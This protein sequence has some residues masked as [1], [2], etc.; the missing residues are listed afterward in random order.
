VEN[1]VQMRVE[2]RAMVGVKLRA[3]HARNLGLIVG[4]AHRIEQVGLARVGYGW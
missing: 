4:S 3:A 2:L 1:R